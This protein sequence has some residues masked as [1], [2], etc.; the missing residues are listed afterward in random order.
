MDEVCLCWC[1]YE[2]GQHQHSC[3]TCSASVCCVRVEWGG[4]ERGKECAF[5]T[6][7]ASVLEGKQQVALCAGVKLSNRIV[8]EKRCTNWGVCVSW[9]LYLCWPRKVKACYEKAESERN[10]A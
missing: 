1:R 2:G 9:M 7:F 5:A 3:T 4:L 8:I 10:S 6:S